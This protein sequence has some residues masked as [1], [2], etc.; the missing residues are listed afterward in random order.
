MGKGRKD[1]D[2]WTLWNNNA[3][4][5]DRCVTFLCRL[6]GTVPITFTF[7]AVPA[8]VMPISETGKL[9]NGIVVRN[10]GCR[11]SVSGCFSYFETTGSECREPRVKSVVPEQPKGQHKGGQGSQAEYLDRFNDQF[12]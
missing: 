3:G 6:L 4:N 7:T 10:H 1:E 9:K 8:K 2:S 12:E 11:D 5:D